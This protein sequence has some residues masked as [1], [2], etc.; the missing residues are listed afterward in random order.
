MLLILVGVLVNIT[1][2]YFLTIEKTNLRCYIQFVLNYIVNI[3]VTNVIKIFKFFLL[4]YIYI[5]NIRVFL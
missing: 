3:K 1:Y 5:Y 4:I 2:A